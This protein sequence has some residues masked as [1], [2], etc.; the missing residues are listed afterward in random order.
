MKSIPP[1]LLAFC[2]Q[3]AC[4]TLPDTQTESKAAATVKELA[5][6]TQSWNGAPLPEYPKGQPKVTILRITIP[7]G[8]QLDTHQHPVINAGILLS[9]QLTVVAKDGK[10]LHL[11]A[12]DPIVELVNTS[13]YGINEGNAPAEIVVFYAGTTDL[14]ITVIDPKQDNGL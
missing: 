14:P 6:T 12:G 10:K 5:K 9:G 3:T 4:S 7:A 11:Q 8:A 13:H 2:L 1:L